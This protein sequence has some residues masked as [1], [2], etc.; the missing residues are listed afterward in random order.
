MELTRRYMFHGDAVAIGGRIVRPQNL[1]LDP[2]CASALPVTGGRTSSTIKKTSFGKYVS[3]E[4]ASTSAEGFLTSTKQAVAISQGRLEREQASTAT[5]VRADVKG[6]VVG[7]KPKL[8]VKRVVAALGAKSA[9]VGQETSVRVQSDS[10]IEG[11]SIGGHRLEIKLSAS[12]FQRCDTCEKLLADVAAPTP[13]TAKDHQHHLLSRAPDTSHE[14]PPHD[15]IAIHGTIV[16]SIRW[17][18]E[19][20]P[21]A[22][23]D[24]HVVTV[25][26]FG[27]IFFG[28]VAVAKMSRRLTMIRFEFGSPFGGEAAIGDV[29]DNGTWS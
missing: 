17:V 1:V 12:L 15:Y 28:E 7:T 10:S 13:K 25:P 14:H 22:T 5:T 11:V 3:F 23:I 19:P 4:S 8:E 16:K 18:G 2:K 24:G 27:R 6:L 9:P 26:D 29:Q 21:G 20:Y